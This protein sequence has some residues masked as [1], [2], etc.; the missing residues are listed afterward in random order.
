MQDAT[1]APT[2]LVQDQ[3]E[4]NEEKV[5]SEKKESSLHGSRMEKVPVNP[6]NRPLEPITLQNVC[7]ASVS[8]LDAYMF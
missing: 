5:V 1:D 4:K 6:K 2:E 3:A 7:V 8:L